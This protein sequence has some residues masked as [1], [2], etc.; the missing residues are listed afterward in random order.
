MGSLSPS[1]FRSPRVSIVQL[2][3]CSMIA[4]ERV[5]FWRSLRAKMYAKLNKENSLQ[6]VD[7]VVLDFGWVSEL[8]K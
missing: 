4:M 2:G 1:R 8:V 7:L 3:F 5:E 6:R